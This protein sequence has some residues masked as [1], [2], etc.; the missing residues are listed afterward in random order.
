MKKYEIVK[1]HEEFNE[2]IQTGEKIKIHFYIFNLGK[3][4]LNFQDLALRLEKN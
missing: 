4:T 3:A 2:I 1:T